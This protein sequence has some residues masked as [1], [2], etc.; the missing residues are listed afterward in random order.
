MPSR[1]SLLVVLCCLI[2]PIGF[3]LGRWSGSTTT[4]VVDAPSRDASTSA[5]RSSQNVVSSANDGVNYSAVTIENLGQVEFDQA[6]E[7]IRSAPKQ[8]LMAW[9]RRLENL[10][11][12]PRKTAAINMFFKTISQIDTRTAVDLALAMDRNDPRWTAIKAVAVAAPYSN[13]DDV[14]RMY[15]AIGPTSQSIVGDFIAKWS[16]VDPEATARFLASYPGQ[17]DNRDIEP[18]VAN[19]AAV[20]PNAAQDWL[21]KTDASRRD[22]SMYESFYLGWLLK[23][24]NSAVQDLAARA[25]DKMFETAVKRVNEEVFSESPDAARNFVLALPPDRQAAAV[26]QITGHITNFYVGGDYLHL[27]ADEVTKWLVTLPDSL[28]QQVGNVIDSWMSSDSSA[29]DAWLNGMS[30]QA[31]DRLLA[32]HFRASH[33]SD[34]PTAAFQSALSISDRTRRE[35][36]FREVFAKMDAEK[37]KELLEKPKLPPEQAAELRRILKRL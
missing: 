19:W 26:D 20:D 29:V 4:A 16:T 17:V 33:Y 6:F 36:V 18:F 37:R 13:L 31:R 12:A 27:K 9:T 35:D 2:A 32:E 5:A 34:D 21:A 10:P 1:R 28:W 23:D 25:T 24:R 14:A 8:A 22:A 30:V 7:L 3:A 15:A 11:L